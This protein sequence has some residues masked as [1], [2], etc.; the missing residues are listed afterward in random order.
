MPPSLLS[1][2]C[3]KGWWTYLDTCVP[4]L[5]SP[6]PVQSCYWRSEQWP[7][8]WPKIESK[9]LWR[10]TSTSLQLKLRIRADSDPGNLYI[11]TT[12]FN[13]RWQQCSWNVHDEASDVVQCNSEIKL[14][15][16]VKHKWNAKKDTIFRLTRGLSGR[17]PD[18]LEHRVP[19]TIATNQH[20]SW[21]Q[22]SCWISKDHEI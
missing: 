10:S 2:T 18:N 7:R 4:K 20:W 17:Q 1:I 9:N 15:V 21:V 16:F 6:T 8:L 19:A 12:G 3:A 14:P 13:A 11:A 5:P 22:R